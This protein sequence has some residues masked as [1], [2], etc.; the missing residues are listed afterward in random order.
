[1]YIAENGAAFTDKVVDG[2]I[3][4][5]GRQ[6]YL[7]RHLAALS[8]ARALGVAVN[9]YFVWSFLDNFEWGH[10]YLQRFGIMH[11][12]FQ[13]LERRLKDSGRWLRALLRARRR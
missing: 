4:D 6:A 8:E 12:D 10:G 11:V 9:G 2:R 5:G 7:E 3:A 1:V 13:T